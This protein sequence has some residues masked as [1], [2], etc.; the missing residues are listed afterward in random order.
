MTGDTSRAGSR[1]GGSGR[2]RRRCFWGLSRWSETHRPSWKRGRM[3]R[4]DCTAFSGLSETHNENISD[5][6]RSVSPE[7]QCDFVNSWGNACNKDGGV[8]R[9]EK[10]LYQGTFFDPIEDILIFQLLSMFLKRTMVF[11]SFHAFSEPNCHPMSIQRIIL[12]TAQKKQRLYRRGFNIWRTDAM[13]TRGYQDESCFGKVA[14]S[15]FLFSEESKSNTRF[16]VSPFPISMAFS[17]NTQACLLIPQWCCDWH[18]VE[19]DNIYRKWVSSLSTIRLI[20]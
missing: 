18:F 17:L 11:H 7:F 4:S 2:P 1:Q 9:S 12:E 8:I 14:S 13:T 5:D 15:T 20:Q 10:S 16:L 3:L 19:G 6:R